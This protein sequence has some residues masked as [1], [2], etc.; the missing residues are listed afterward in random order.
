MALAAGATA[1]DVLQVRRAATRL[2]E[3]PDSAILD[4]IDDPAA[5]AQWRE[6][7]LTRPQSIEECAASDAAERRSPR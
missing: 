6:Q 5:Y 1:R 2:L 4:D 7:A 3:V